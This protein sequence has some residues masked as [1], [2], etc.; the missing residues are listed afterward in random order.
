MLRVRGRTPSAPFGGATKATPKAAMEARERSRSFALGKERRGKMEGLS[1]RSLRKSKKLNHR[2][3]HAREY[4]PARECSLL[5]RRVPR[6][7]RLPEVQDPRDRRLDC[8]RQRI[9]LQLCRRR[10]RCAT[11]R[12]KPWQ[13][14]GREA[15]GQP[16][17]EETCRRG[18][19]RAGRERFRP[20]IRRSP[21]GR[22]CVFFIEGFDT[23]WMGRSSASASA[24][25]WWA[26]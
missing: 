15:E 9:Q 17:P 23:L 1:R 3:D 25:V 20:K 21:D 22:H 12:S 18:A 16:P 14:Q 8:R 11:S 13:V 5:R 24:N 6:K 7:S 10:R 4:D 19:A 2:A 26:R